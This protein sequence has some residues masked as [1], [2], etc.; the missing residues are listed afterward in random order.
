MLYPLPQAWTGWTPMPHC[1]FLAATRD[2]LRPIMNYIDKTAQ[3]GEGTTLGHFCVIQQDVCIGAQCRIGHHVVIHPGTVIGDGVRIDDH[4]VI[5]KTPMRAA[6]SAITKLKALPPAAIGDRCIVGSG[7]I[8]YRG[9]SIG[10]DVLVADMA[11]VREE[12]E[13]GEFTIIGRGVAVENQ[14]QIGRRCKIETEAYITALSKV[15]NYCFIAPEA[16]F[17]NDNFMGR[18]AERFKHFKGVV[19]KDGSRVGANA[20]VLPGVVIGE[21]GVVGAGAVV[22]RDVPSKCVVYGNPAAER[23]PVPEDQLLDNQEGLK[24]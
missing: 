22:T 21:D 3:L 1:C 6:A 11:S 23:R 19:M 16:T 20:T 15:G 13:I 24:K 7:V 4:T 12:V 2:I 9:C 18:S 17:T 5:G 10:T 8:L 14:V